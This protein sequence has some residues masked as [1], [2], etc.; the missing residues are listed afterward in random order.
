[1]M[2]IKANINTK[3]IRLITKALLILLCFSSI[4]IQAQNQ[5]DLS[6]GQKEYLLRFAHPLNTYEPDSKDTAMG[7]DFKLGIHESQ[8]GYEGTLVYFLNSLEIPIFILDLK[9]LKQD[10]DPF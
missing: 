3:R 7:Q 10:N 5:G 9:A 8:Q 6:S 2:E 4:A 1:M